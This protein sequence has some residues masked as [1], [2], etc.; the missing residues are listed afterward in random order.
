[1]LLEIKT[2]DNFRLIQI[3]R[4]DKLNALNIE[5]IQELGREIDSAVEDENIHGII[6][7]GKGD[8]AFAAGADISE[9]VKFSQA[10]GEEMAAKGHKVFNKLENSP[11]PTL[12]L[13]NGF[14]LGG[15]CELA[16]ACHFRIAVPEAKFGQPEIKLG[17]IPGY[18]GT[19]RLVRLI[20][21]TR[22]L[23]V[24]LSSAMLSAADALNY[25]LISEIADAEELEERGIVF[26]KGVTKYS[27]MATEK[28]ID[29]V[30]A[31]SDIS[32]DGFKDE[33]KAFGASFQTHDFK[34]GTDAFLSKRKANFR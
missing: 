8:K 32:R 26:M 1:M 17:L 25:G 6:L 24:L 23:H 31:A 34:E 19:Q 27:P 4:P 16:M 12:A 11:K 14:A 13:V 2:I 18:G 20:G 5:L 15:G 29:L 3:N 22:T 33:I 21:T 30:N 28:I 9:F 7:R 10:Q